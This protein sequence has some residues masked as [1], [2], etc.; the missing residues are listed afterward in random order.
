M[1]P[2]SPPLRCALAID[3]SA[4]FAV[5]FPFLDCPAYPPLSLLYLI[6]P[7]NHPLRSPAAAPPSRYLSLPSLPSFAHTLTKL[8]PRSA[9][10]PCADVV[11]GH[12]HHSPSAS[13]SHVCDTRMGIAIVGLVMNALEVAEE[14]L[15]VGGM[16]G[17]R[18]HISVE[19]EKRRGHG[20]WRHERH[21]HACALVRGDGLYAAL[22]LGMWASG[23]NTS[24]CRASLA[25]PRCKS[26]GSEAYLFFLACEAGQGAGG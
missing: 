2:P 22:A 20:D 11:H 16:R 19:E 3:A 15:R 26:S 4:L 6:L 13:R 24:T 23:R 9:T 7:P 17:C 21:G 18:L 12:C 1:S 10:S 14:L 25:R 8:A 5:L